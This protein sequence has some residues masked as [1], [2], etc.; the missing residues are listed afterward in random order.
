MTTPEQ[1]RTV[2][3]RGTITLTA[4]AHQTSPDG[5]TD[6]LTSQMK[7]AL[8]SWQGGVGKLR[9]NVPYITANSVRA[10]T[11]RAAGAV[12]MEELYRAHNQISRPMYLSIMRGGFARTGINAGGATWKQLNAAQDHLFAGLWG[13]GANMYQSKVRMERDLYPMLEC[14]RRIFPARE[15]AG[16]IDAT[17]EQILGRTLIASRD[18]FERLPQFDVIEN[19]AAA[20]EAHMGAKFG[21]N[22]A[23]REQKASAKADGVYLNDSEKL[24]TDDLNT[25]TMVET[26]I[27]G[28]PLAYGITLEKVTDGQIGLMLNAIAA[29]A[30]RNALGGGSVRG[31]GAFAA[32]LHMLEGEN[33]LAEQL[34]TD[35]APNYKLSAQVE[36]FTKA[37]RDEIVQ[38]SLPTTLN[39]IYPTEIAAKKEKPAKKTAE[40]LAE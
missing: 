36:H 13:G 6:G 34:F 29:W 1:R 3:I 22:L 4:M 24:K 31:R 8:I 28:T 5:K 18:D 12:L 27:P 9:P 39:A 2:S 30:N 26:I 20:Y 38:A 10:L 16:C 25:F 32:S 17:P 23:K 40:A 7:T 11:R 37:M 14:L 21:A 15:Q 33:T 19:Y 35:D